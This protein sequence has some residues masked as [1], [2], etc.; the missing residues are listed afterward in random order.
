MRTI[1]IAGACALIVLTL[2]ID[3]A[4]AAGADGSTPPPTSATPPLMSKE[5]AVLTRQGISAARA[6]Q[7]LDVQ[8][9]VAQAGLVNKLQAA[10]GSA[11]AGAWFDPATAQ[12]HI[13]VATPASR[14]TL[15]EVVGR[16]GLTAHAS[17]LPVRSTSSELIAVQNQWN[18]KLASLIE[19][20]QAAT[21]I[22]PQHNA[23]AVTLGSSISAAQRA[24]IQQ[25][26]STAN[27]NVLVTV[28]PRPRLNP[29]PAVPKTECNNFA[30]LK[31]YCNPSIT[32]GVTIVTKRNTFTL[33]EG[34]GQ[35]HSNTTLDGF[36]ESVL[37]YAEP[38]P[39]NTVTGN[40]IPAGTKVNA[41][42]TKTS[43]TISNAAT[44]TE[45]TTYKFGGKLFCSAGPIGIPNANK[46]E[47]ILLTAGHCIEAGGGNGEEWL[48][49]KRNV[50]ELLIG[51]A[52]ANFVFGGAAGAKKGDY[53]EIPIEAAGGWQT[54]NAKI[55]VFAVSAEWGKAEEISY[56]VKEARVAVVGQDSC[57]EGQ[58]TGESCGLVTEVNRT[59]AYEAGHVVEGLIT[60]AGA[61]LNIEGG[62]SGGPFLY[63]IPGN[64]NHEVI[65]EGIASG[66]EGAVEPAHTAFY[67]PLLKPEP[68]LLEGALE[69]LGLQLLTTGNEDRTKEIEEE[70]KKEKEEKERRFT[71]TSGSGTL[72]AG[73]DVVTCK[74]DTGTGELPSTMLMNNV[75]IHFLECTSSGA[76]KSGCSVKSTNTS[77]AGLILTAT[78]HGVIGTVLPSKAAGLLLLAA[79]GKTFATLAGNECTPET[80][81]TGTVAGLITPTGKS[82]TTSKVTFSAPGGKQEIKDID[83]LGGLVEPELVAFSV[84]ATEETAEEITWGKAVEI[85]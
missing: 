75:V 72:K 19:G 44:A 12:I 65:M 1:A 68:G 32:P 4:P 33:G 58:T 9:K 71:S 21:G 59:V 30:R 41:K 7:F 8:G 36:V 29:T 16:A 62:D 57:H 60:V 81:V 54:G 48:A 74:K 50:E 47:R 45:K 49:F 85:P 13:G 77:V 34:E 78:L 37:K 6:G 73:A 3:L 15:E 56:P 66:L 82:Q 53:G 25:E 40:D 28:V 46:K 55:P 38:V 80:K 35:S 14:R 27:V 17:F 64:A 76:S 43:V 39:G 42:P 11:Y 18:A 22:Q 67:Q 52:N 26:A 51:K 10:M 24:A 2:G 5:L 31:A 20:Q 83:T 23:V 63:L 61:E 84:S 79:S 70:E 69:K